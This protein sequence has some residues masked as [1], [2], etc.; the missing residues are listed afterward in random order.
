LTAGPKLA[1]FECQEWKVIT[2]AG[3]AAAALQAGE[4][5]WWESAP[6]DFRALLARAPGVVL[7][8]PDTNG[9]YASLRF[10]H[11]RPP[12]TTRTLGGPC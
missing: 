12:S 4:V 7:G 11:L 10:N 1:W 2:D 6:P 5:D 9:V 8:Q 3:T